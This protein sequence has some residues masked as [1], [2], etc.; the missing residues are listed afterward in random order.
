MVL[1]QGQHYFFRRPD[2]AERFAA[3]HGVSPEPL[4]VWQGP[5]DTEPCRYW[6]VY[7]Y[8]TADGMA[9]WGGVMIERASPLSTMEEMDGLRSLIVSEGGFAGAVITGI[10]RMGT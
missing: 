10:H 1:A 2:V 8:V 6:L 7:T 4:H 5:P 3:L 9:G